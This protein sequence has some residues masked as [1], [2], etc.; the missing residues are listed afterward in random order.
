[1][2]ENLDGQTLVTTR[3]S[4]I[5]FG[6]NTSSIDD[7]DELDEEPDARTS[8]TSFSKRCSISTTCWGTD[9]DNDPDH[10]DS[11][12]D[13]WPN[14]VDIRHKGPI[15]DENV[16]SDSEEEDVLDQEW[17]ER[18]ITF[19][20]DRLLEHYCIGVDPRRP[21]SARTPW[22]V[23]PPIC[24]QRRHVIRARCWWTL[25]ETCASRV[26]TLA[27]LVFSYALK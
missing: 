21:P 12:V 3:G 23:T 14:Q 7:A 26:K 15:V 11:D 1:M 5:S 27:K 25:L 24:Q 22:A 18:R 4:V 16:L 9:I 13:T 20:V 19:L 17:S 10:E 6:T 2:S 8:G